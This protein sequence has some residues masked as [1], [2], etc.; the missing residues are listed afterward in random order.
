MATKSWRNLLTGDVEEDHDSSLLLLRDGVE[1][2]RVEVYH[3]V[4]VIKRV[5]LL[6]ISQQLRHL[7]VLLQNYV[8]Q[9]STVRLLARK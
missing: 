8:P 7:V 1:R 5:G 3:I 9:D 2:R 6:K 4:L